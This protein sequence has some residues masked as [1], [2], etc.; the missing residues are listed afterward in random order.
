M[1][2]IESTF[3]VP[4]VLL[5]VIHPVDWDTALESL[6]IAHD[7]GVKGVFLINQGL[8]SDEVL[9]LVLVARKRFPPLWIGVNLLGCSPAEA[10]RRGLDGCDGRIDGIWSDNAAIDEHAATQPKAEEL[11]DI[12]RDRGWTGLY[13]GGVAFKH[14]RAVAGAD[15]A[16]AAAVASRFM[17]VICTSGAGTG[18][19]ADVDKVI[20]IRDGAAKAAVALASGV[21]PENVASYL[22]YVDAF[23]VGTGIEQSFG[24]LDAT[25]LAALHAHIAGWSG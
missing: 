5:P 8:S 7:A 21:T 18:I 22:P 16:R 12:R 20:A 11:L 13:F 19:A 15:L 6:R 9:R 3:G 10:L 23:L 25:K 1:N 24:V 4:R 2:R 14:Q 17:D